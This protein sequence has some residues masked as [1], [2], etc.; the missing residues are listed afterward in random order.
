MG[1]GPCWCV[2]RRSFH[3][4]DLARTILTVGALAATIVVTMCVERR[5][6]I[7]TVWR[8]SLW[9]A[10]A[11][12]VLQTVARRG[13][14]RRPSTCSNSAVWIRLSSESAL[15]RKESFPLFVP[16]SWVSLAH[17]VRSMQKSLRHDSV[18]FR[19]G[20]PPGLCVSLPRVRNQPQSLMTERQTET[21]TET[22]TE[23]RRPSYEETLLDHFPLL[24]QRHRLLVVQLFYSYDSTALTPLVCDDEE[25]LPPFVH[26]R[27]APLPPSS[28]QWK[29]RVHILWRLWFCLVTFSVAG[30]AM[31]VRSGTR[32]TQSRW[33]VWRSPF[34]QR[35]PMRLEVFPLFVPS[36]R[37][38]SIFSFARRTVS[39]S[40]SWACPR[41]KFGQPASVPK[42]SSSVSIDVNA[43]VNHSQSCRSQ[44]FFGLWVPVRASGFQ[45][46]FPHRRLRGEHC[47]HHLRCR[48]TGGHDRRNDVRRMVL[49]G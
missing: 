7:L 3:D 9:A 25:V 1:S 44:R 42:A 39:R 17:G 12:D 22:E 46:E 45:S 23:T 49:H 2:P 26:C 14:I 40:A 48:R 11:G 13:K 6:E 29:G 41:P 15:E 18:V 37:A 20:D 35:T 16:S 19:C 31:D 27:A 24:Q 28:N 10:G 36:P 30:A 21:R 34:W 47:L 5:R 8:A 4:D 38:S 32:E 43:G 33:L